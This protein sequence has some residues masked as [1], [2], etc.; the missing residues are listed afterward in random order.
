MRNALI[1]ALIAGSI[2]VLVACEKKEEAPAAAAPAAA[3]KSA[4][5]AAPEAATPAPTTPAIPAV[6]AAPEV[7]ATPSAP[8]VPAMTPETPAAAAKS[9]DEAATE[10]FAKIREL[11]AADSFDAARAMLDA[12][13]KQ[14]AQLSGVNQNQIGVLRADLE[15]KAEA[16]KK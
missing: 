2:S 5:P 3:V 1:V 12:V 6:P 9:P 15:S 8:A 13:D 4:A 10:S 7:P 16:K 11:I 14:S